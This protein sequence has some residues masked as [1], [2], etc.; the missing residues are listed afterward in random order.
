MIMLLVLVVVFVI[1]VIGAVWSHRA[2]VRAELN[3][4]IETHAPVVMG[5]APA[6]PDEEGIP[7]PNTGF[8]NRAVFDIWLITARQTVI[9]D[10]KLAKLGAQPSV[11]LITLRDASI[12]LD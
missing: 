7:N 1:C 4:L 2:Q 8:C 12:A 3:E 11:H 10:G 6:A 5:S 9:L